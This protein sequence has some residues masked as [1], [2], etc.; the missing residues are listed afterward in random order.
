VRQ[1]GIG[2][3]TR[4]IR[5]LEIG[6]SGDEY[7]DPVF[8]KPFHF[9]MLAAMCQRLGV[10]GI[11]WDGPLQAFA[12]RMQLWEALGLEPPVNVRQRDHTG[13]FLPLAALKHENAVNEY[14][15]QLCTIATSQGEITDETRDSLFVALSEILYNCF[16]HA[17]ITEDCWGMTCAQSWPRGSLVQIAVV[18]AGIGVRA[19]LSDNERLLTRLQQ[20]NACELA[21]ELNVTGKPNAGHS[22]YGL[23]VAKELMA[24]NGGNFLLISGSEAYRRYG[25]RDIRLELQGLNW[26]GTIVVL[27]WRTDRPLDIGA[28]Y[29]GWPLPEG[30]TDDDFNI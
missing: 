7:R 11:T 6:A 4:W 15:D 27:E 30:M 5:E 8:V 19:S 17:A 26:Q 12:A 10:D 2:D 18:D 22:G 3:V 13:R 25:N 24:Q 28:V 21:T 16:A 23:T 20:E 29:A 9:A 1:T 14:A